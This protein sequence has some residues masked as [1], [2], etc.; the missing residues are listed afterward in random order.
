MPSEQVGQ[1]EQGP[2]QSTSV[3]APFLI[4]SEQV[5][6]AA[7]HGPPQSIPASLWFWMPSEQVGHALHGPPQ[8]TPVSPWFWIPSEQ[9]GQA[10]QGPPQSTPVSAPFLIPSKQVGQAAQGPPQSTPVSPWF[11]TLSEQVGAG[12]DVTALAYEKL[13]CGPAAEVTVTVTPADMCKHGAIM[14]RT[15]ARLLLC[16][17]GTAYE[18]SNRHAVQGLSLIHI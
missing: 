14:I 5:A 3:S 4:P 7:L 16:E 10:A 15:F 11:W 1:A 6:Q 8:S 13:I 2:P 17:H 18:I 9:V 12:P